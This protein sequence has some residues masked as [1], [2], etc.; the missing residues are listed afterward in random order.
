M[1][2]QK[3][4]A[5]FI[6]KIV[7]AEHRFAKHLTKQRKNGTGGQP[8]VYPRICMRHLG[9]HLGRNHLADWLCHCTQEKVKMI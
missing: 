1:T 9:N 5:L 7:I 2:N 6:A 3:D 4:V 8:N